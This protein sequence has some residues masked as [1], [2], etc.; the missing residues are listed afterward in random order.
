MAELSS[1]TNDYV[2][3]LSKLIQDSRYRALKQK[4]VIEGKQMINELLPF[5]N[6]GTLLYTSPPHFPVPPLFEQIQISEKIAKK[7][8]SV[9]N[10]REVFLET[11]LPKNPLP[12]TCSRL[13]VLDGVGDPGNLGTLLRT[14]L[15]LG[16]DG[17]Y[18]LLNCSD[19][20]NDK[21]LRA[22]KGALFRLPYAQGTWEDLDRLNLHL[23]IYGADLEGD[24]PETI[25][26]CKMM[27]ILGNEGQG[28]SMQSKSR[29]KKITIPMMPGVESLNVAAAGAILM[30]ALRTK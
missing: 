2:R 7:L 21:A 22:S 25:L 29:C 10:E 18:F 20:F 15:A 28:L 23:D 24:L 4:A 6:E 9:K 17:V 26:S 12:I 8:S 1:E 13:L 14:C 5:L 11:P 27:L 19:P 30:Y 16:W 3:H